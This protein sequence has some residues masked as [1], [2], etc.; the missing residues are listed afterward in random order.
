MKKLINITLLSLLITFIG[1]GKA[2]SD[3]EPIVQKKKSCYITLNI[4]GGESGTF[5]KKDGVQ[6]L[7]DGKETNSPNIGLG[8]EGFNMLFSNGDWETRYVMFVLQIKSAV[9]EGHYE[10]DGLTNLG[11]GGSGTDLS[12]RLEPG[13]F[14]MFYFK[15]DEKI[16][17][18]PDDGSCF[19]KGSG[20]VGKTE[21]TITKYTNN[22]DGHWLYEGTF[23]AQLYGTKNPNGC[24]SDEA[25]NMTGSFY[26]E[27]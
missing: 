23:K 1:C 22:N 12:Y 21:V 7:K 11:G 15:T 8:P 27:N 24:A 4:E 5:G 6:L 20:I 25:I 18:T 16:I 17:R 13:E 14:N 10:F 9:G 3:S 2:E 26:S 19:E